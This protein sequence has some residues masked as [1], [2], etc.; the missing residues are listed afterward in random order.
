LRRTSAVDAVFAMPVELEKDAH[1]DDVLDD[2][3]G[4][5]NVVCDDAGDGF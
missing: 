5:D 1:G 3:A 4:K 2:S